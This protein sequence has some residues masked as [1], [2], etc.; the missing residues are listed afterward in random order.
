MG[1]RNRKLQ[2][3]AEFIS[4]YAPSLLTQASAP[5]EF[6]DLLNAGSSWSSAFTEG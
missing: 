3:Y 4:A 5:Y 1:V 2:G 6:V